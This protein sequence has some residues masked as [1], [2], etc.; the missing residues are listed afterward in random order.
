MTFT[1]ALPPDTPGTLPAEP[2][3]GTTATLKGVLNPGAARDF[4]PGTYEFRYRQSATECEGGAST[5][6]AK[7]LGHKQEAVAAAVTGL[8][9]RTQYTFCRLARNEAEET[10]ETAVGGPQT[11][12]TPAIAPTVLD[13]FSSEVTSDSATL[14]AHI[15][16]G[17]ADTKYRFEHGP[18]ASYGTSL[19]SPKALL[20]KA[21]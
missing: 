10:E 6:T 19:L 9:P 11:F 12:T 2:V 14:G 15:D 18:T 20:A 4:E 13:E 16:P 5:A 21:P 3:A 7:A 17:G 8:T 1:T